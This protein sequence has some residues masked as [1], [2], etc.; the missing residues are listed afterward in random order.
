MMSI[1][2]EPNNSKDKAIIYLL[3]FKCF[4]DESDYLMYHVCVLND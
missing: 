2:E 4:L 3:A 1:L